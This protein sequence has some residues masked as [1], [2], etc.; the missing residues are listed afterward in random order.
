[1]SVDREY[2]KKVINEIMDTVDEVLTMITKPFD[3]L[4]KS[5]LMAI[6]YYLIVLAEAL[7]SL[8]LHIARRS[9]GKRPLSPT[10]AV[11]ILRDHHLITSEECDD[12]IRLMR[13][14][15]LLVHRY[16]TIDDKKIYDNVKRN[17]KKILSV[18][19]KIAKYVQI[20]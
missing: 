2:V 5:D 6:R 16:W 11:R 10:E 8:A 18:V 12:I 19:N 7:S 20:L 3:S 15:N 13:L 1:M 14:R 9:L 17:F 4:S